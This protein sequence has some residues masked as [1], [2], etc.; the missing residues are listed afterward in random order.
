V[1]YFVSENQEIREIFMRDAPLEAFEDLDKM[2]TKYS[3]E[4]DIWLG[5]TK[6]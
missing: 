2:M 5:E 6:A 4:I 3:K 1:N